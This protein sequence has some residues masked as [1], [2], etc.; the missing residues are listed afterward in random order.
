MTTSRDD[1]D[2]L[3]DAHLL[4]ALRHAPD[5]EA[6]PPPDV[7]ARVLAA[8]HAAVRADRAQPSWAQ[9]LAAWWGA[10]RVGV[11]AAF[12]TLVAAVLVGVLWSTR[13]PL[14]PP[15]QPGGPSPIVAAPERRGQ[16]GTAAPSAPPAISAQA[17]RDAA[18]SAAAKEAQRPVPPAPARA[19]E[20]QQ[21]AEQRAAKVQ[22]G[23]QPP[24]VQAAPPA[25]AVPA[26]EPSR[27]APPPAP[28]KAQTDAA[29][30][31][32]SAAAT[33][34]H[35]RPA[36]LGRL[37]GRRE[38]TNASSAP[39]ADA[40]MSSQTAGAAADPL[41][42]LDTLVLAQTPDAARVTWRTA[43]TLVHGP[44]Q[45]AWWRE[46][47]AATQGRWQPAEPAPQAF[48][49]WLTLS[50]D[51]GARARW[52][53]QGDHLLLVDAQG[54]TWR[55]PLGAVQARAWSEAVAGW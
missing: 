53:L 30:A 50:I 17:A 28:P 40:R 22:G 49:P 24:E 41:S 18:P 8:A 25:P 29:A 32:P 20:R 16:D 54:A 51:G 48:A 42:A 43:R 10:P 27:A 38:D 44:A 35:Q 2:T 21:N 4:A 5:R 31:P 9:R 15:S 12:G 55:V 47:R 46:L 52:W 11:G 3:R 6:V 39:S 23:R 14:P 7:T 37:S 19:A 33:P 26:P 34:S 36:E 1:D 45:Q 13:E